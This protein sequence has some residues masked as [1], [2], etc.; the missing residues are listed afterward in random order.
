MELLQ[1]SHALEQIGLNGP[2][3]PGTIQ[4][5]QFLGVSVPSGTE[6]S[7]GFLLALHSALS[8][9]ILRSLDDR[10][11]HAALESQRDAI[12]L[13]PRAEQPSAAIIGLHGA[14]DSGRRFA[15]VFH[16]IAE[17]VPIRLVCPS[18]DAVSW[19]DS[20]VD[21]VLRIA[22][23]LASDGLPVF[24]V[25]LSDGAGFAWSLRSKL[26]STIRGIVAFAA[27]PWKRASPPSRL[28]ILFLHGTEDRLFAP[29]QLR[30]YVEGLRDE[31][32]EIKLLDGIGHAF[33]YEL[34]DAHA[35]PWML[36]RTG[37]SETPL[38]QPSAERLRILA[39]RW[40]ELWQRGDIGAVDALHAP[41][42]IDRAPAGRPGDREGFKSGVTEL[43]AAFPDFHAVT[44][45]L[46]VDV[47]GARVAVRW[48]ATG[49]HQGVF[50]GC[51]PTGKRVTFRGIE[52]LHVT[53]GLVV[54][55][56]GE[57]D[58]L[59]LQGQLTENRTR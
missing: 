34:L 17:T 5:C 30:E 58:G 41:N 20:D 55:R 56:W 12:G 35:W 14:G 42:F 52:I 19:M 28:P 39:R 59:D 22:A 6:A 10:Y 1:A 27:A 21:T 36:E 43:Y 45:D 18:S 50:L 38:Q 53:D 9:R 40:M 29:R 2:V 51:S 24:V 7:P 4:L 54:E 8:E 25:G 57:W 31:H 13:H 23:E 47:Q 3:P 44:E 33:P 15:A 37:N 32:V 48:T 46:I 11:E 16:R 26:E 49:T